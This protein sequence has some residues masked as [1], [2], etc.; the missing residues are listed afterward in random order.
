MKAQVLH[1]KMELIGYIGSMYLLIFKKQI[2]NM[3][4]LFQIITILAPLSIV[5]YHLSKLRKDIVNEDHNG[6]WCAFL[7]SWFKGKTKR[8][9]KNPKL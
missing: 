1:Y 2:F 3:D 8:K 9:P 4:Q 6:S 7:I 5:L